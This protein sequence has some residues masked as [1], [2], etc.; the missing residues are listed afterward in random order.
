MHRA[1]AHHSTPER[2]PL[3]PA[4]QRRA[5]A[6]MNPQTHLAIDYV[7]TFNE[8]VMLIEHLPDMPELIHNIKAWEPSSYTDYF[9]HSPLPDCADVLRAFSKVD[10]R[11]RDDFE[12][13]I[14]E[15]SALAD[16]SVKKVSHCATR[17]SEC[18]KV[19]LTL[20]CTQSTKNLRATLQRARQLINP[21]AAN[22]ERSEQERIDAFFR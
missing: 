1:R 8:I 2:P 10:N 5:N 21:T 4:L 15:L 20:I 13:I 18:S 11:L 14:A 6:L 12:H 3:R 7:N 22:D 17:P 19:C 9:S 16:G